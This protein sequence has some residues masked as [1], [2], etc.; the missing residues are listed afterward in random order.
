MV[1]RRCLY[2][3]QF[4]VKNVQ[5]WL[6]DKIFS[7]H[8][9]SRIF[10]PPICYFT[11]NLLTNNTDR[12]CNLSNSIHYKLI[13]SNFLL[14]PWFYNIRILVRILRCF[15]TSISYLS[16]GYNRLP[17]SRFKMRI[18]YKILT[19]PTQSISKTLL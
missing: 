11:S 16:F 1:R 17:S 7:L 14:L 18:L 9:S 8:H 15:V 2:N 19:A 12:H 3:K 5:I 6:R 13:Q 10:L 4:E